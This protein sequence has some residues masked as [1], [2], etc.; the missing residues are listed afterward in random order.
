MPK[1]FAEKGRDDVVLR[2]HES[3]SVTE[4]RRHY[5]LNRVLLQ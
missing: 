5:C 1:F 2:Q 3:G 4:Q